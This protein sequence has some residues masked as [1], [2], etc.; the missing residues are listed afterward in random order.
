M[1]YIIVW[2]NIPLTETAKTTLGQVQNHLGSLSGP[3]S[4]YKPV[5]DA[6]VSSNWDETNEDDRLSRDKKIRYG[7]SGG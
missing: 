2:G 7:S 4:F 6:V 3:P 1:R 5:A